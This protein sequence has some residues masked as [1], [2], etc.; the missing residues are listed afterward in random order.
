M[1]IDLLLTSDNLIKAKKNFQTI[2]NDVNATPTAP[3]NILEPTVIVDYSENY[4]KA[5]YIYIDLYKRYY[6]I[7]EIISDI[8]KKIK[9]I[10]TVDSVTSWIDYLQ[11]CDITVVRNEGIGEP[12]KI[13][14]NK[15]PVSPNEKKVT[16][17]PVSDYN[18]TNSH[19]DS[20]GIYI[21]QCIGG[22]INGD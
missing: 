16:Q 15:L 22:H 8:G 6:K 3:I 21:L 10:C 13:P 14:D 18:I 4:L 9:F 20:T 19:L 1:L 7:L 5:N 12:T 17:V 2:E 11:N